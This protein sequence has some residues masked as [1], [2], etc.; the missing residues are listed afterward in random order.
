MQDPKP[1]IGNNPFLAINKTF[2]NKKAPFKAEKGA[3]NDHP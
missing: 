1:T 3:K 2:W